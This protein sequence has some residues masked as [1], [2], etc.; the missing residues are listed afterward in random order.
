MDS[1]LIWKTLVFS[2]IK[3]TIYTEEV[4][5]AILFYLLANHQGGKYPAPHVCGIYF[6]ENIWI[7]FDNS[8]GDCWVEEFEEMSEAYEW[9]AEDIFD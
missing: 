5:K 4:A 8:S 1:P 3:M 9:I 2:N 7:A 6:E